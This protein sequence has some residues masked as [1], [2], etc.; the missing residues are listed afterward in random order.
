MNHDLE[1]A[2]EI[3]LFEQGVSVRRIAEQ[4]GKP[5]S[6]VQDWKMRWENT[7]SLNRIDGSGRKKPSTERQDTGSINFLQDFKQWWRREG[8]STFPAQ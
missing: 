2:R 8:K 3:N 4:L 6:T 7:G 5:K 1:D